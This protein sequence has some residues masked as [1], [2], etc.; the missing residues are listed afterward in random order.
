MNTKVF[1][2]TNVKCAGCVAKIQTKL[3][4]LPGITKAQVNLLDKTLFI[5]YS[6]ELPDKQVIAS[7]SALGFG[8]SLE[9][10]K[11]ESNNLL[12]PVGLPLIVGLLLMAIGMFPSFMLKFA[13][14][15]GLIIGISESLLT[16]LIMLFAGYKVFKSG[17]IGF[18][19][20]VFNMHSLILLGVGAAWLYSSLTI[21]Y[22]HYFNH[23]ALAHVYF[24][25]ALIILALVN[26]GG[27]LEERAKAT[28][29]DAIKS[30]TKLIP[31][32]TKIIKNGEEIELATNLLRTGYLVKVRPGGRIAADGEIIEGDGYLD[33]SMLTGEAM[34]IHKKPGDKVIS[35]SINTS[36]A[37]IFRVDAVGG[38]TFLA[39]I[40]NL[41]KSAQL[42]KPKLAILADKIAQYFV[43]AI[44]AVAIISAIFW[45]IFIGSDKLYHSLSSFMTVLIIACPCSVGLAIPVALMVGIGRGAKSG[46]LIKDASCL[47]S[48]DRLDTVLIDKTG[49]ITQ[50]IPQVVAAQYAKTP[51]AN[52]YLA[53]LKAL[54]QNSEHPLAYAI[55]A[56]QP[57]I[58]K[59]YNLSDFKSLSG[60][61][62]SGIIDNMQYFAVS[63]AK[64]ELLVTEDSE[65][66]VNNHFSQVYLV[67][68]GRVLMRV[69]ISDQL[70]SDSASAI[71]RLQGL[72]I[73]VAML[74]GDNSANA[75]YIA[76]SVN[77]KQVFANCKPQDK[78][79]VIK[80]AQAQGKI[81][82]FIGDGV[83]DA[84][85]LAQ[86]DVGI[87]IGSKTDI[88]MQSASISLMSGSL[89]SAVAAINL[90]QAI[91]I[92][93]RQNLFGSFIY[94]LLAVLVASGL[95]YPWLHIT[96]DPVI[97]SVVMSLSSLTVITNA[98]RLNRWMPPN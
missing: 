14:T 27:Y 81:V 87:A 19:T 17:F 70:K 68:Q 55:L 53:I 7:L 9:K 5:E 47:S 16:L 88:A 94:N 69:D 45:F 36:G 2:L 13:S 92:N 34:P 71:K 3:T 41:V 63:K 66:L 20:L 26:L 58:T 65:L 84:P 91:N 86:A 97:A 76:K 85:S 29:T 57:D 54:E 77:I 46:I 62:V 50:G 89:N 33:E 74:T 32:T 72:G 35:G 56:Y 10:I 23:E 75:E 73:E 6:A 93:M 37:F 11:A 61:G 42:T 59:A 79:S 51:Y 1:N 60:E 38:N 28:T 44:I 12:F 30:L 43:P 90:A 15:K 4:E 21:F 39:E 83:N 67:S 52:D 8:A 95:F 80:A 22:V 40:I 64:A 78:V 49:T 96:L 82:A 18:K 48:I 25:S 98:L 31:E 24:E